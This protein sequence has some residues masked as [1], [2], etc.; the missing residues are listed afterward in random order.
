MSRQRRV[1][2]TLPLAVAFLYFLLLTLLTAAPSAR[3]QDSS[4]KHPDDF[5]ITALFGGVAPWEPIERLAI[6]SKGEGVLSKADPEEK[7][8]GR[9]EFVEQ[10]R[11]QIAGD[12]LD[13]IYAAV[14]Q[15]D[16]F[17][18]NES[19]RDDEV[20]DGSFAELTIAAGQ[21]TRRVRTQNIAIDR[22]D[23]VVRAINAATQE[24]NDIIYNEI[25]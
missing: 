16:F 23:N 10:K 9:L 18:L 17:G 1:S 20:L 19:Y 12:A 7:M 24:D 8:E 15:N 21:K 4:S 14:M 6:N 2:E 11:F 3:A 25:L 13:A 5:H 22:F